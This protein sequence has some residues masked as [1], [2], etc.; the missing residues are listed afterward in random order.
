MKRLIIIIL[1]M[2]GTRLFAQDTTLSDQE[3]VFISYKLSK[4]QDGDK[5]DT[6]LLSVKATNKNAFDLFYQGPKNGVNPFFSEVTVRTLNDYIYLT[7]TPSKL[8]TTDGKLYYI[9]AG[10]TVNGETEFKIGKGITPVITSKLVTELKQ[11]SDF[12]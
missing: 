12:R 11:I 7:A 8:M 6:Y 3:G 4:L 1:L 5:K 10:G 2:A 9:K